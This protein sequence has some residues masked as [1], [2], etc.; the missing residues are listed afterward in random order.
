MRRCSIIEAP[1]VLG[2]WPGGV[3]QLPQ[4]LLG[5]GLMDRLGAVH[6]GRLEPPPFNPER[7]RET[8]LLNPR[9]IAAYARRLADTIGDTLARGQ[10]P[11]VL[12]GDCSIL[13][14]GLLALRRQ[15]RP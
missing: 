1:S 11:L 4:V 3:E 6:G 15:E 14:G 8:G 2:L 9:A 5:E 7:D 13:L 12:G 10:F